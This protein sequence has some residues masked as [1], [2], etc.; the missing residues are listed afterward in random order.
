MG[1]RDEFGIPKIPPPRKATPQDR[2][3]PKTI[4][5]TLSETQLEDASLTAYNTLV[6]NTP[7]KAPPVVG[8]VQQKTSQ[9]QTYWAPAPRQNLPPLSNVRQISAEE[10]VSF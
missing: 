2:E 9:G 3:P 4:H 6:G 10:L 7:R 1:K 8:A 5:P